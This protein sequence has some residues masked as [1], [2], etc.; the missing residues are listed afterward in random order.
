MLFSRNPSTGVVECYTDDGEYIGVM[1]SM[2]D[3]LEDDDKAE[4][5]GRDAKAED[6]D[7]G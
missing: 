5:N 4:A 2:G 3:T 1:A 7:K 6:T